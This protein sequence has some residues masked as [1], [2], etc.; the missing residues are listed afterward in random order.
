MWIFDCTAGRCPSPL[1]CSRVNCTN[2]WPAIGHSLVT[3]LVKNQTA[4]RE[5]WFQSLGWEDPVE[6]RITTQPSIL[7]WRIPWTCI[8]HGFAKSR[9]GLS[10]FHFLSVNLN[11]CN[12]LHWF[13]LWSFIMQ[14]YLHNFAKMLERCPAEGS[15]ARRLGSRGH[16]VLSLPLQGQKQEGHAMWAARTRTRGQPGRGV[17][18]DRVTGVGL[19]HKVGLP[20]GTWR[21]QVT[22]DQ[23]AGTKSPQLGRW[24]S[25]ERWVRRRTLGWD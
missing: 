5:T 15:E 22:T 2:K 19:H 1:R 11:S 6:K 12:A 25:W 23:G 13:F 14:K 21:S 3:Q 4:M 7:A 24:C 18:W 20:W 8:V 17:L 10:T 9:T 16:S